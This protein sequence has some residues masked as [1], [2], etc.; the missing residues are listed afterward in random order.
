MMQWAAISRAL[1]FF[2]FFLEFFFLKNYDRKYD[3]MGC[4]K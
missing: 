3:A 2:L 4:N 1:T